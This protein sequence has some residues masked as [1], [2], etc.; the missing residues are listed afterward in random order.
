MRAAVLRGTRLIT[1]EKRPIPKVK[2]GEA[3]VRIKAAAICGSDL[4]GYQG[5]WPDKRAVGLVMG[6]EVAGQIVEVDGQVKTRKAGDRVAIDPQ[7]TCGG[8]DECL[9]GW[10]NICSNMRLMGSSARG[11]FDGGFAEYVA[12]PEKNLYPLPEN[13]SFEEGAMIDPLANAIHLVNRAQLEVGGTVAIFGAGSL[14]LVLLQVARIAGAGVVF[15]TDLSSYRLGMADSLGADVCITAGKRDPVEIILEKTKGKG[16]DIAIEAVG[17]K[18]TYRQCISVASKR[19]KVMA[20]GNFQDFVN[21]ELFRFVSRELSMIG[22]TGFSPK[23]IDRGLRLIA[24]GKINV[25]L[26]ITHRLKLDQAQEAFEVLD[27][28]KEDAIKLILIP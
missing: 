17:I 21:V 27:G 9:Q 2:A 6:H 14:G 7:L 19:G 5:T 25:K 1:V 8:C 15:V 4:H 22:C 13:L 23:E 16:V 24:S 26:L 28:R 11:A 20:L 12:M 10:P 18:E 3:L